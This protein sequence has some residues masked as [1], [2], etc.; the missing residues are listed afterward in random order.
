MN[1]QFIQEM[2][3]LFFKQVIQEKD[4][5]EHSMVAL[6]RM[7]IMYIMLAILTELLFLLKRLDLFH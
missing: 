5:M 6:L 3:S 2:E 7:I 4:G 1:L